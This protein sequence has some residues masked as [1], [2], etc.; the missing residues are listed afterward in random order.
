MTRV[1]HLMTNP[2]QTHNPVT[3]PWSNS[4]PGYLV[5]ILLLWLALGIFDINSGVVY[6]DRTHAYNEFSQDLHITLIWE[7]YSFIK[8]DGMGNLEAPLV[9]MSSYFLTKG[10][11]FDPTICYKR[12]NWVES[13]GLQ[14]D[15]LFSSAEH[16]CSKKCPLTIS[17]LVW[18]PPLHRPHLHVPPNPKLHQSRCSTKI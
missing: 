18:L 5:N 12:N 16:Y 4:S 7:A 1:H 15:A 11:K 6:G 10:G 2:S 13:R 14:E 9:M 8:L 17:S 3:M